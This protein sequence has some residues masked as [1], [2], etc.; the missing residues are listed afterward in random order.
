MDSNILL[1]GQLDGERLSPSSEDLVGF[2]NSISKDLGFS[3]IMFVLPA[4]GDLGKETVGKIAESLSKASRNPVEL[5]FMENPAFEHPHPLLLADALEALALEHTP[6]IITFPHSMLSCQ[7]A[8]SLSTRLAAP[9]VTGVEAFSYK[10]A[11]LVFERSLMNGRWKAMVSPTASPW[12]VTLNSG[13]FA[14][15]NV[16]NSQVNVLRRNFLK[17]NDHY[18]HLGMEPLTA[19]NSSL[20]KAEVIVS[21]GRGMIAGSQ[22]LDLVHEVIEILKNAALGASRPLCDSQILP[23][24]CQ[25][26]ETGRQVAPRLYLALGI[27]GAPQHLAGMRGAQCVIAVN[28]DPDA[29]IFNRADYAVI[30]DASEFLPLLV[31]KYH[32]TMSE[33]KN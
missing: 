2:A 8:A 28:S 7:V 15:Q 24:S 12:V 32:E 25:I 16:Q 14:V 13:A 5:L 1:V 9:V 3:R 11:Q 21:A 31:K 20:E 4:T 30:A 19:Q 17:T 22:W 23:Y 33:R 6:Q 26:G 18:V 10:N 27:S 29:P